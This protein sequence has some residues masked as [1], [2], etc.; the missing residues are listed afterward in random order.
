MMLFLN[1]FYICLCV[2]LERG[3]K[4]LDIVSKGSKFFVEIRGTVW[5]RHRAIKMPIPHLR[6]SLSSSP[7]CTWRPP[8]GGHSV[9]VWSALCQWSGRSVLRNGKKKWHEYHRVRSDPRNCLRYCFI[10]WSSH[11]RQFLHDH[12]DQ[13]LREVLGSPGPTAD[14]EE[15]RFGQCIQIFFVCKTFTCL[16]EFEAE[17][18]FL[19]FTDLITNP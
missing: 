10:A 16:S 3:W 1:S 17:I 9:F 4:G 14:T 19:S 13:Q 11:C 5:L 6:R 2:V 12:N 8:M 18:K 15:W 7:H